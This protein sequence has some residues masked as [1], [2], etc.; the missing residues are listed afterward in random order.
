[1]GDFRNQAMGAAFK[2]FITA[3][4]GVILGL[5]GDR[6]LNS[7]LEYKIASRDG[8][9]SAPLGERGL[10]FFHDGKALSNVSLVEFGFFN[11]TSKQFGDVDL[12]FTISDP[13]HEFTL[14]SAGITTPNGIPNADVIEAIGSK[15]PQTR[16]FRVKVIPKQRDAEFFHAVFVFA[17]DKAPQ[18][19]VVSLSK[20]APIEPYKEWKDATKVILIL[21]VAVVCAIIFLVLFFSLVDHFVEPR[22][23]KRRVKKFEAH[24]REMDAAGQVSFSTPDALGDAIKAY[25]SFTKPPTS[26]FLSRIFGE[27]T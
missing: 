5:A 25:A 14:V 26:K 21:V 3:V 12:A 9:L 4:V 10:T 8:Y 27:R 17:G 6:W 22:I 2:A 13:K 1:M 24:A 7:E 23:H 18:M 15:N 16:T 20:D 19:S 11:R